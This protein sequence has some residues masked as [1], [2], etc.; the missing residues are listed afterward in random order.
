MDAAARLR[1]PLERTIADGH[2]W[3]FRDAFAD[4]RAAP[5]TVV[6]VVDR[7][8]RFVARGIADGGPIGVRVWTT[9]DEP[10]DD[11]LLG[12]RIA[13]AA[14]MRVGIVP[15]ETDAYRLIHG[16]G[17]RMPGVVCDVYGAVAVLALDGEG[18]I[19]WQGR[20]VQATT[21]TLRA[22][23]IETLL[24]R[25][26]RRGA[27]VVETAWGTAPEVA[28]R[29]R[30]HGRTLVADP[31]R[32]QKTGL[33]LDH[34]E[35]RRRVFEI[36]RGRRVLDLYAYTGGFSAAAGLGGAAHVTTV[37]SAPVAID[38][39]R[40]TWQANGL[41]PAKQEAATC[42]VPEWLAGARGTYDLVIADPPS[43]APS[44]KA[45]PRALASYRALHEGVLRKLAAGGLYLAAS[46]S[47]HVGWDAWSAALQS[48]A[49]QA[50]RTV[51]LLERWGAPADHP[52]LLA[53]PEG[54]YL[55]VALM[56]V[57]E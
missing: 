56:R 10:L 37:D 38:L 15:P 44:E 25:M 16:E 9:R 17:D 45:V 23:G 53:F 4:L 3:I 14:A 26:G 28:V 40:E 50:G 30:E 42:D 33:F 8:D 47:S 34:R 31:V 55:D 24:V 35:S 18:A 11:D 51:Q 6:T 2:P 49:R 54:D 39:A 41:D 5:G 21:S 19:A 13:G 22:L 43:F 20:F 36:A 57:V 32:G 48:G 7:S 52:R 1:K 12:R 29:V 27:R 46:C